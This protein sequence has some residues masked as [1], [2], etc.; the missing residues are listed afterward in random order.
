MDKPPRRLTPSPQPL[1]VPRPLG[2]PILGP[3]DSRAVGSRPTRQ[4]PPNTDDPAGCA[5]ASALLQA[6]HAPFV[7]EEA[8]RAAPASSGWSTALEVHPLM[9]TTSEPTPRLRE[10][11]AG[12][13]GGAWDP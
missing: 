5:G 9:A 1:C 2:G 8:M 7:C 13:G 4:K 3:S 6:Q 11:Q 12:W 10:P